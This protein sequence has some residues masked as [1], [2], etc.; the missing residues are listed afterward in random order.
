M[1]PLIIKTDKQKK[2]AKFYNRTHRRLTFLKEMLTSWKAFKMRINAKKEYLL[3]KHFDQNNAMSE[4]D[5]LAL[6]QFTKAFGMINGILSRYH[7]KP[8]DVKVDLFR[9]KDHPEYGLAPEHLGWKKAA[10]K[11]VTIHNIPGDNFDIRESPFDKV[12]AR[13]FQEILDERHVNLYS[14]VSL[15]QERSNKLP[16]FL[17]TLTLINFFLFESFQVDLPLYLV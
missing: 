12:L 8:Q 7:L 13:M 16:T 1:I 4:Q 15:K 11:G 3:N 10:L 17:R 14:E 6:E 9:S 5:T 2:L